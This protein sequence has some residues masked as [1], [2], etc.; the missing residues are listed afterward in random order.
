MIAHGNGNR[1]VD[2]NHPNRRVFAELAGRASITGE[3]RSAV[4]ERIVVQEFERLVV[5]VDSNN[6]KNRT[7]DL[8]AV[9]VHIRSDIVDQRTGTEA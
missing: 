9:H 7:E 3:D 5:G 8:V 2:T 6:G 4:A 1:N